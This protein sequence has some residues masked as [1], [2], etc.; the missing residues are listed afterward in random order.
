MWRPNV[1]LASPSE[2]G[3]GQAKR[4]TD[5]RAYLLSFCLEEVASLEE[6]KVHEITH[7]SPDRC[8]GEKRENQFW[9]QDTPETGNKGTLAFQKYSEL[10][11][12]SLE[13]NLGF[14]LL[15][16]KGKEGEGD[17]GEDEG[18]SWVGREMGR[19]WEEIR[20]KINYMEKHFYSL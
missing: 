20:I 4:L 19:S 8:W 14:L 1:V 9:G 15:E 3:N 12:G 2:E 6:K 18:E 10:V 11:S 17:V 13:K 5:L 7:S 16:E